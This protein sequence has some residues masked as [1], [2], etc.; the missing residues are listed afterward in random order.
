MR[1]VREITAEEENF[2]TE[3]FYR[4]EY[5]TCSFIKRDPIEPEPIGTIILTAFRIIGYD[6]DY[7]GSLM[8]RLEHINKDGTATGWTQ[9][10]IGLYPSCDLVVTEEE[11]LNLF[12]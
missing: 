12:K 3:E 11:L 1:P 2:R 7:D 4:D 10:Q 5:K 8:A 9:G 6:K